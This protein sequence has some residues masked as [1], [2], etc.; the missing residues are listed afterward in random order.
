MIQ[1]IADTHAIVW[2]LGN[3]SRLSPVARSRFED[4][5]LAGE[6]IGISAITIVEMIF[7]VE[8]NRIDADHLA[9]LRTMLS[10]RRALVRVV[11]LNRA[12]SDA[13][14]EVVR[15]E[16]PEMGDRMIAATALYLRVPIITRD[17]DLTGSR[18]PTTW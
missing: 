5:R 10:R 18:V 2:Y 15:A 11:P 14:Q 12:V 9:V 4:A 3:D 1:V 8:R 17:Q 16:V 13:L 7:L 6:H